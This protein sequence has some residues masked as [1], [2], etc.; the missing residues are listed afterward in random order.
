MIL[1]IYFFIIVSGSWFTKQDHRETTDFRTVS[2]LA[3]YR[4]FDKWRRG[5]YHNDNVHNFS[6]VLRM[7]TKSAAL[8]DVE[9]QNVSGGVSST[10]NLLPAEKAL[11]VLPYTYM[12]RIFNNISI[13]IWLV[14]NN[15]KKIILL[16]LQVWKFMRM[17]GYLLLSHTKTT[18]RIS[19]KL[20]SI[21]VYTSE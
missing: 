8:Y 4:L 19:M 15:N 16:V 5:I 11:I 7:A 6:R 13:W 1:F 9:I 18:E 10:E 17:D 20:Y 3:C 21:I 12:R 2:S 14:F